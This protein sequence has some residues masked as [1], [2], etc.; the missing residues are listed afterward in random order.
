MPSRY[1][2]W[3]RQ[4]ERDL[5]HARHALEDEDYEWACFAAHQAAEKAVKAYTTSWGLKRA[6]TR[7]LF[8]WPDFRRKRLPIRLLLNR[9]R[10]W[11]STI[12]P[13]ISERLSGGR[14]L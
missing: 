2:D 9:P 14:A 11:T 10:A 13:P 8:S 3:W 6:D 5:Q 7:S 12:S 1:L 4:A